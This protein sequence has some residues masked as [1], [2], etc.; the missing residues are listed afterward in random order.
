MR[1]SILKL[2]RG[3][4][5]GIFLTVFAVLAFAETQT[6]HHSTETPPKAAQEHS[7]KDTKTTP[8]K[9]D[10]KVKKKKL[11]PWEA[12]DKYREQMIT[13]SRQLGVTCTHCHDARNYREST[14]KTFQVAKNHMEMVDMINE[15][16]K[17]SFSDKVDC[18]MC[19]KGQAKPEFKEPKEKI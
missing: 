3:A 16:F 1:N 9:A 10:A 2:K 7:K 12:W 17:Y 18:Y 5:S 19:H 15:R 13:I 14:K 4:L 11:E 8:A 6:E